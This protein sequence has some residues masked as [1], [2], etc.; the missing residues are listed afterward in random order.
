M[1]PRPLLLLATFAAATSPDLGKDA[2]ER[3]EG[4][5][6]DGFTR[7]PMGGVLATVLGSSWLFYRA[8]RGHNPKVNSFY[9]A[10]VYCS[11]N[12][13]VGYCDIFAHTA[14]GKVIGTALMTYGPA[15]AARIFEPP[16]DPAAPPEATPKDVVARLDRILAAL[17]T[18][19]VTERS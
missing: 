10:L 15:M 2:V 11:T 4:G 9:D 7:D 3:I 19:K 16:V 8:E 13:S 14:A 1:N 17:E 12:I 18:L 6:R 5:L